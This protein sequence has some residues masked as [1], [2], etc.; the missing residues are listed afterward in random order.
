[1]GLLLLAFGGFF[2]LLF[3]LNSILQTARG[4]ACLGFIGT[5]LAFITM[6]VSLWGL[7][8]NQ[9]APHP[10]TN[11]ATSVIATAVIVSGFLILIFEFRR[12]PRNLVQSRG[13]LSIGIGILLLTSTFTVPFLAAYFAVIPDTP[14]VSA[15]SSPTSQADS[16]ETED[17][18]VQEQFARFFRNIFQIVGEAT[19]LDN[20]TMVRQLNT[21]GMTVAKL[22]ENNDGDLDAVVKGVVDLTRVQIQTLMSEGQVNRLQGAL[23]LSNLEFFIR[24]AINSPVEPDRL[25]DL[26]ELLMATEAPTAS[27]EFTSTPLPTATTTP[28]RTRTPRPSPT[29]TATRERFATRTPTMTTTLPNP[30]LALVDYNLNV[31]AAPDPNA[32]VLTVIPYNSTITLF[33]QSE[34]LAWWL[35]TY[36]D[37]EGWVSGEYI[38]ISDSCAELPTR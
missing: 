26:S 3:I 18:A 19:G 27:E 28:T 12:S 35:T 31:R 25:D 33:A 34:D 5:S 6:G 29:A 13:I 11:L 24:T 22:I 8:E 10:F 4:Q 1:M 2:A 23:I 32:E 37:V 36:E 15:I 30:C 14:A 7:I 21:D 20:Q 38:R 17:S 9:S 16:R